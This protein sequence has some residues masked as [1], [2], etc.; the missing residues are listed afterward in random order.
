MNFVV[1]G[2][3]GSQECCVTLSLEDIELELTYA[4]VLSCSLHPKSRVLS[5][6]EHTLCL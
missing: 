6:E 3:V 2:E 1:Q 5:Q 4:V